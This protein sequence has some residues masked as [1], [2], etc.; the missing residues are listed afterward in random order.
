MFDVIEVVQIVGKTDNHLESGLWYCF[1]FKSSLTVCWNVKAVGKSMKNIDIIEM[2][3]EKP[4]KKLASPP[5][6]QLSQ[7]IFT[8]MWYKL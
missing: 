3:T 4:N 1:L 7:E 6:A 2:V 5:M 8:I